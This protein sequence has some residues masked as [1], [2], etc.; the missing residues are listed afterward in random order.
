MSCGG[1]L[2]TERKNDKVLHK[3]AQKNLLI[4]G[5]KPFYTKYV[6]KV[7]LCKTR[8]NEGG[9]PRAGGTPRIRPKKR[10]SIAQKDTKKPPC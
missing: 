7:F 2:P 1:A 6:F 3:K 4:K 9:I 8:S 5:G 10:Q